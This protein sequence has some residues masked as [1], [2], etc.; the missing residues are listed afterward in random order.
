MTTELYYITGGSARGQ[1]VKPKT[2]RILFYNAFTPPENTCI[3]LFYL[4]LTS[5]KW[6][7]NALFY[8]NYRFTL[9]IGIYYHRKHYIYW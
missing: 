6:Q 5:K 7:E 1:K 2:W 8:W 4:L 3:L 9:V